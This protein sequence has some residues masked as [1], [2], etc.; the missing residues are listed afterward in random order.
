MK[1]LG[2][3]VGLGDE[4]PIYHDVK[5]NI[6][7]AGDTVS[8]MDVLLVNDLGEKKILRVPI[9]AETREFYARVSPLKPTRKPSKQLRAR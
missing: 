6:L 4:R 3:V 2:E 8:H 1:N 7:V 9:S 5:G